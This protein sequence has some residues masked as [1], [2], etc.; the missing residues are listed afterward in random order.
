MIKLVATDIDGTLIPEGAETL[1]EE[2]FDTIRELKKRDILFAAS[3]GRQYA[4]M[5]RLFAPVADDIIFISDNG[6]IVMCR[7]R[8]MASSFIEAPLAEELV[9]LI[10][11]EEGCELLLSTPE[12]MY[13]DTK[14]RE[15]YELL[16]NGYHNK[17]DAV[18]D[19]LACCGRCVNK[20]SLYRRS[21]VEDLAVEMKAKYGDRLNIVIA[22]S[23]WIDFMNPAADKGRALA[24]IQE[25]M[26]I[27]VDETMAFG[28]NDNDIGM[29]TRAAESYA[30]ENAQPRVKE[31]ARYL[32]ASYRENGVIQVI[33]EELL[34]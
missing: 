8:V 6:S 10:R 11:R 32:A 20:V 17:V 22:G 27:G 2:L 12:T 16:V 30:V 14:D 19:L 33:R 13:V 21:G 1:P 15:Y 34:R 9:R 23:L 24:S 3:S 7:G 5:R 29:L 18:D 4:S 31:A 28:D 26:R 25:L